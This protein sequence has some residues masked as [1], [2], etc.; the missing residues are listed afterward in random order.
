MEPKKRY[1]GPSQCSQSESTIQL[2]RPKLFTTVSSASFFSLLGHCWHI[3]IKQHY[4]IS[5][6]RAQ[7][8]F[9]DGLLQKQVWEKS[10][11]VSVSPSSGV[12]L[13]RRC[14]HTDVLTARWWGS[15]SVCF[16]TE[17][18]WEMAVTDL[19]KKKTEGNGTKQRECCGLF[20]WTTNPLILLLPSAQKS[21]ESEGFTPK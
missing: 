15:A 18:T 12:W 5:H 9:L 4:W 17:S 8:W 21:K 10:L 20:N 7:N 2:R 16:L 11:L 1:P 3:A 13:W 6:V 19:Q 14:V